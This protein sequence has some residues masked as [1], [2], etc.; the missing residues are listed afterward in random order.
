[1][2]RRIWFGRALVGL[3][4]FAATGAAEPIAC[5]GCPPR[6]PPT[7]EQQLH[8]SVGKSVWIARGRFER[9]DSG[10]Q[11]RILAGGRSFV[12]VTFSVD[13]ALMGPATDSRLPM[14]AAAYRPREA[15]RFELWW[16]RIVGGRSLDDLDAEL[17]ELERQ[18]AAGDLEAADY[19]RG[20]E[21]VREQILRSP[22]YHAGSHLL[23]GLDC[24]FGMHDTPYRSA[25]VLVELGAPYV[26]MT[27]SDPALGT[28]PHSLFSWMFDLHP[29]S[30]E[31]PTPE[32]LSPLA[33]E[34]RRMGELG[35]L[36]SGDAVFV[37]EVVQ[38]P[39]ETCEETPVAPSRDLGFDTV[40][41]RVED[42]LRGDLGSVSSIEVRHPR[43]GADVVVRR[44]SPEL[45]RV[46]ARLLVVVSRREA[47]WYASEGTAF[48]KRAA[49]EEVRYLRRML[50]SIRVVR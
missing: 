37:G 14:S 3:L 19:T 35:Y 2:R 1:M 31:L 5:V 39:G 34:A 29:A 6:P 48:P 24:G 27:F 50:N 11:R 43:V 8:A 18:L 13:E 42:V 30:L 32:E 25:D 33:I 41:Y 26:L 10:R 17:R 40:R 36:V 12:G 23:V 21:R 44:V 20:R 28:G 16:T 49:P 38:G 22:A 7:L 47:A 4:V 9:N 45:A 46:G 15:P